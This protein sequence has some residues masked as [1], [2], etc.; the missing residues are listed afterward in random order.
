MPAAPAVSVKKPQPATLFTRLKDAPNTSPLLHDDG[1]RVARDRFFR[2]AAFYRERT[3]LR[4]QAPLE[5]RQGGDACYSCN[6]YIEHQPCTGARHC[7]V[8]ILVASIVSNGFFSS[9]YSLAAAASDA[10][11]A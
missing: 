6:S 3:M 5:G 9:A 7:S 8:A 10:A 4:A 2:A 1:A 11:A